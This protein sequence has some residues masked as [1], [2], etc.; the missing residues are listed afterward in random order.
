MDSLSNSLSRVE[1]VV[2][3]QGLEGPLLAG[4]AGVLGWSEE[5][6]KLISRLSDRYTNPVA[7]IKGDHPWEN[8]HG[9]RTADRR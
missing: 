4:L 9:P 5:T 3:S 6:E 2:G 8:S 1:Q 7:K